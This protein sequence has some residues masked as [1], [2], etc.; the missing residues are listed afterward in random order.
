MLERVRSIGAGVISSRSDALVGSP[1]LLPVSV[2]DSSQV[3]AFVIEELRETTGCVA[4]LG[5]VDV[6]GG[7]GE[8]IVSDNGVEIRAENILDLGRRLAALRA[9]LAKRCA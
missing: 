5:R 1:Y 4:G 9:F 3:A 2:R 7:V 8:P 6:Y